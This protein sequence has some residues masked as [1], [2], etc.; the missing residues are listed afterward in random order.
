MPE[1]RAGIDY[2]LAGQGDAGTLSGILRN[3]PMTGWVRL[4]L[5]REPDYFAADALMG[6]AATLLAQCGEDPVGMCRLQRL[7]AWVNGEKTDAGYLAGLRVLPRYRHRLSVLRGGFA[8]IRKLGI[9]EGAT[10]V[11]FTSIAADNAS[12]RR[13]LEAGLPRMPV[14]RPLARL[15]TLAFA[16]SQGRESAG[17][18]FA[19]AADIP[20]IAAF[21][22]SEAA[23][24]QFAPCLDERWLSTL[25]DAQAIAIGDFLLGE[26]NGEL[27]ACVALWDQRR[28]KQTV[29]QS[30][31]APLGALRPLWN[32]AAR[33]GGRIGLPPPGRALDQA[34][35]AFLAST[36]DTAGTLA[37]LHGALWHLRRRG[38]AAGVLG[39]ADAN[40]LLA[41][42]RRAMPAI[43]FETCIESVA[44][45]GDP[46]PALDGRVPQPEAALL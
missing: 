37:L 41:A 7:P 22:R 40:P 5:L 12:A 3:A 32:L 24:W 42:I 15:H 9:P 18:R 21:H 45:A 13:V 46:E 43:A 38:I 27:R 33:L 34:Y 14:Y 4:Q 44:F 6:E 11:C 36:L 20:R 19:T 17:L 2:R 28:L 31:R 30:Y 35:L 29:A 1:I 8:A 16:T 26:E 25:T 23:R 39:L 10:P